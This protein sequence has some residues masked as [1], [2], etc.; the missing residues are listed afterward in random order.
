MWE[1]NAFPYR[2]ERFTYWRIERYQRE[3]A[4]RTKANKVRIETS[5]RIA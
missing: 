5:N 4:R 1:G 3:L 2:V